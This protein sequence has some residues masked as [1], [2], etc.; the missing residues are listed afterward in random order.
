MCVFVTEVISYV[1]NF[2]DLNLMLLMW[3]PAC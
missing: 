1:H 3:D 2:H